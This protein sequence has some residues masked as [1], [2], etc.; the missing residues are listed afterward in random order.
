M[1]MTIQFNI[2]DV[3]INRLNDEELKEISFAILLY[4]LNRDIPAFSSDKL[5]LVFSVILR[6]TEKD[7]TFFQEVEQNKKT[8]S[9]INRENIMKRWEKNKPTNI[10]TN[11]TNDTKN[12]TNYTNTNSYDT[13]KNTNYTNVISYDTKKN[14]INS[15]KF[16]NNI[17]TTDNNNNIEPID[18]KEKNTNS[19]TT[20]TITDVENTQNQNAPRKYT[21]PLQRL[22]AEFVEQKK[23]ENDPNSAKVKVKNSFKEELQLPDI[24]KEYKE[25]P[26]P[27][28]SIGNVLAGMKIEVKTENLK[29]EREE[30][31]EN[32]ERKERTKEKK[33]T[34]EEKEAKEENKSYNI[35]LHPSRNFQQHLQAQTA[36]EAEQT[37]EAKQVSVDELSIDDFLEPSDTGSQ[38]EPVNKPTVSKAKRQKKEFVPPTLADVEAYCKEKNLDV[39]AE[40]WFNYYEANDWKVKLKGSSLSAMRNWKQA[41]LTWHN[42]NKRYKTVSAAAAKTTV[43][44]INITD[45]VKAVEENTEK[46]KNRECKHRENSNAS[47][48]EKKNIRSAEEVMRYCESVF[49]IPSEYMSALWENTKPRT[50]EQKSAEMM[51]KDFVNNGYK[52][53]RNLIFFGKYGVG[54]TYYSILTANT[55]FQYKQINDYFYTKLSHF[56]SGIKNEFSSNKRGEVY[57]S[58]VNT[59]LLVL[60]EFGQGKLSEFDMQT[61]SDVIDDRY[62]NNLSTIFI[63]NMSMTDFFETLS[64]SVASR[65]S[66]N[67]VF[68]DFGEKDLRRTK[69]EV[70]DEKL[71]V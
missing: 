52:T 16:V 51:V 12:N 13:K 15:Y 46:V 49:N 14:R 10:N 33:E 17:S 11:D 7:I 67:S 56:L 42:N 57:E 36:S 60:D 65:L 48:A 50:D 66:K 8:R 5:D 3:F 9:E 31:E 40:H 54:K 39:D 6:D 1:K 62:G 23:K 58:A 47:T 26:K 38:P 24:I 21:T 20:A 69:E 45:Y 34:K 41:V 37:D 64:P 71:Q 22:L 32:K 4:N 18:N 61:I 27:M 28:R 70:Y 25:D 63:T 19:T 30:K 2:D 35:I 44:I 55:C 43:P 53:G 68:I 29:E 59:D